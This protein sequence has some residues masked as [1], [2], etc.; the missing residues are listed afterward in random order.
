[1][2]Q[3]CYIHSSSRVH[4]CGGIP[5]QLLVLTYYSAWYSILHRRTVLLICLFFIFSSP[6]RLMGMLRTVGSMVSVYYSM[7]GFF[8][9][10]PYFWRR[11]EIA[12]NFAEK[13]HGVMHFQL[14]TVRHNL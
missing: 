10:S 4:M 1:M 2:V 11:G 5:D 9:S 13:C 14:C 6:G 8:A 12:L 3:A 7:I